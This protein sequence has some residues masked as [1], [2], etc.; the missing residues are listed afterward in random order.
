MAQGDAA[1]AGLVHRQRE[2]LA[3][4]KPQ[5]LILDGTGSQPGIVDAATGPLSLSPSQ[6]VGN[7]ATGVLA[8]GVCRLVTAPG[9]GGQGGR[10]AVLFGSN[11][12]ETPTGL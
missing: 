8:P 12:C 4:H 2:L 6:V 9:A 7:L 10:E 5:Q 11:S 3:G 1:M